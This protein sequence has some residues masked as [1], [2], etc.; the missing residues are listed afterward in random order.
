MIKRR[1]FIAGLGSAA[2][3]PVVARAQQ[4]DHVRRIGVLM[5]FAE[6]DRDGRRPIQTFRQGLADLGWIEGRNLRIDVGWAGPDEARQRRHASDL[7][8]LTPEV[9]LASGTIATQAL[10]DA[11]R[12]NSDRF[13]WSL[14]PRCHRDCFESGAAGRQCHRFHEL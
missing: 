3:W 2:A 10:R 12:T 9:I 6:T 13:R 7:V 5:P 14:R 4:G 11:T 1:Q 8:A